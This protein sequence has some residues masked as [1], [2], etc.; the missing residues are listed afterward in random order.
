MSNE[1]IC[2][3]VVDKDTRIFPYPRHDRNDSDYDEV[4]LALKDGKLQIKSPFKT[5]W[6]DWKYK[7]G[8][9]FIY[10]IECYRRKP[11]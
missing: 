2:R 6:E 8:V 5:D 9:G 7:G 4:R 1:L 10:P 11:E 3:P